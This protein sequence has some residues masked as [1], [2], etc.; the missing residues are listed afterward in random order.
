MAGAGALVVLAAA[1]SVLPGFAASLT[2]TSQNLAGLRTCT[3]SG[4]PAAGTAETGSFVDQN[5]GNQNNVANN[6]FR[7]RSD[8]TKNRRVYI[9]FDLTQC[10]P[11]IPSSATVKLA[12]MRLFMNGITTGGT[13]RTED[14][15]PVTS[16][17]TASAV[18]W[19]TQPFGTTL[20]NPAGSSRTDSLTAGA[21]TGCTNVTNN[22]YVNGWNV[23]ADVQG[24][25][26]GTTTNDGWM[27]R[28]DSEGAS[29]ADEVDFAASHLANASDSP[30]LIVTYR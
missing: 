30:Q 14:I 2:V 7:V 27:I 23:T 4:F 22:S 5:S 26:A 8:S 11:A 18:T 25:V 17:W 29:P 16:A 19:N 12:T 20:N 9:Q 15:F 21:G 3:L 10:S 28:D 6:A 13:C 1:G 24:F